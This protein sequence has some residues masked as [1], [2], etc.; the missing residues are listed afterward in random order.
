MKYTIGWCDSTSLSED[1]EGKSQE[2]IARSRYSLPVKVE[3]T[4]STDDWIDFDVSYEFECEPSELKEKVKEIVDSEQR[5][6][7]VYSVTDENKKVVLTEE[8]EEDEP[9]EELPEQQ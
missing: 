8:A 2:E 7:E 5:S 9:L 4:G 3:M 6:W 1:D